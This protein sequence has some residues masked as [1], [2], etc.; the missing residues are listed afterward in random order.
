MRK[1][2]YETIETGE[3]RE[4]ANRIYVILMTICI[5]CSLIPLAFK[6]ETPLLQLMDKVTVTVF[7]IDY[8]LRLFTADYKYNQGAASFIKYPF[9]PMA[10]IDLVSILPSLTILNQAFKALRIFR[11]ARIT[12]SLRLVKTVRAAKFAR[13]SNTLILII[14]VVKKCKYALLAVAGLAIGYILVTGL[15]IFNVEPDTFNNYFE[16][17][18]W[19]TVS[20]TTVGYG[21]IYSVTTTGR[22]ISMISSFV[23]I[24]V[25][26]LP[27]G[28]VTAEF[29]REL[30]EKDNSSDKKEVEE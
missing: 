15:I 21:D 10:I 1:E 27:S 17:V 11:M 6:E 28:I 30:N 29:V 25:V 23:G 13:F 26:A 19:A 12:R 18:Y 24:A 3:N 8:I 14:N 16:A 5:I 2:I 22:L 7:I 20:L 9:S 4:K